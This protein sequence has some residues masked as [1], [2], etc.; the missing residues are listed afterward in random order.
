[1]MN[2]AQYTPSQDVLDYLHRVDFVGVVG[3]TAVGK[4]TLISRALERD[5]SLHLVCST[6]S[7]EPRPGE[8]SGDGM[9]FRS[10]AKMEQR[11]AAREY[12]QMLRLFNNI[13]ATAPEDYTEEG[14][15]ILPMAADAAAVFR[16]LPF[17]S[18]RIIYV[19]PPSLEVWRDRIE[20]RATNEL[21]KR[22]AEAV[23]SLQ[24]AL[25]NSD[26]VFVLNDDLD[27]ATESFI[28]VLHDH[29][30][31]PEQQAACRH[32]ADALLAHLQQLTT[33]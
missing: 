24:F 14:I 25:Q 6:T 4:S 10:Q 23:I 28:D 16:S 22:M 1:M 7:R 9:H 19:L 11:I 32:L 13:Y 31:D 21:D 29:A 27:V 20:G 15:S 17:H 3:P 30:A 8:L 26:V 33:K 5:P 2:S 12:V 18:L